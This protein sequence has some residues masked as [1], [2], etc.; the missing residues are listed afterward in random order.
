[1]SAP[2]AKPPA[3][4]PADASRSETGAWDAS[5]CARPA[6]M[7]AGWTALPV[8][9]VEKSVVPEP[10]VLAQGVQCRPLVLPPWL[11]AGLASRG[12]Y[13][14]DAVQSAARS[15]SAEVLAV[16]R[17]QPVLPAGR[18][19]SEQLVETLAA[20]EVSPPELRASRSLVA[21]RAPPLPVAG[22]RELTKRLAAPEAR[23]AV[24]PV[25]AEL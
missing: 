3:L 15:S 5:A 24:E 1:M 16:L 14:P 22:P 6:A 9:A 19:W 10:D 20:A 18:P 23:T 17:K 25:A 8:A 11:Q 7:A 2:E 13:I 21:S 12:P 4:L